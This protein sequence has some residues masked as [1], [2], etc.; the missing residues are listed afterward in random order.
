MNLLALFKP[1][2]LYRPRQ[3]LR[4]AALTVAY[5]RQDWVDIGLPW[6]LTIRAKPR[7]NHGRA[8]LSLGVIDLAVTET[9]WRLAQE[10]ETA[11][12]VGAN[13]GYM[14]AVLARR[15]GAGGTVWSFE[16]HPALH[17][18]LL[19]NVAAWRRE[20][21]RTELRPTHV[22]VSERRGQVALHV[23]E[24]FEANRGLASVRAVNVA[25]AGEIQVECAPLDELIGGA[26]VGVLKIDVEGH[27][28]AVLRGSRRLLEERRMRDCV[29]EEHHPYPTDTTRF[30]EERGYTVFRIA[31]G[32]RGPQLLAPRSSAPRSVW[33]P[34]SFIA[35]SDPGRAST[36]LGAR[37]WR[38]LGR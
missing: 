12:D 9:L 28:L 25:E 34:T 38:S 27:E 35:T 6:G 5:P 20:L 16:A 8:L 22:A 11:I 7:E 30:L 13:I 10:G 23:P 37:G 17:Q 36:V 31:R 24:A 4:R 15:V 19:H 32:F 3:L 18:E 14:T 2:Y 21:P 1:E 33:E 26:H 29:F